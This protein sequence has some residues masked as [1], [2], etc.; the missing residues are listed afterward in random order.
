[1]IYRINPIIRGII[2]IAFVIFVVMTGWD[3]LKE[4][5]D[6]AL[7]LLGYFNILVFAAIFVDGILQIIRETTR[8]YKSFTR[9]S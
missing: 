9:K 8:R 7:E 4:K 3:S 2:K 5:P 1:M 6:N